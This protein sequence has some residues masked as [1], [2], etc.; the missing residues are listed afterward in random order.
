[1]MPASSCVGPHTCS[2]GSMI[3][4]SGNFK[5]QFVSGPSLTFGCEACCSRHEMVGRSTY[6]RVAIEDKILGGG[7][8]A[9]KATM[10]LNRIE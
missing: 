8:C 1:M 10:R 5:V 9:L 3:F 6:S 2:M 7:A 4:H